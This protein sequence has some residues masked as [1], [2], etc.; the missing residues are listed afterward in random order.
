MCV[1]ASVWAW[2]SPRCSFL[3]VSCRSLKRGDFSSWLSRAIES[4]GLGTG[5]TSLGTC[6]LFKVPVHTLCGNGFCNI[7]NSFTVMKP[8]KIA[9]Q[10]RKDWIKIYEEI[11]GSKSF[12]LLHIPNKPLFVPLLPQLKFYWSEKVLLKTKIFLIFFLIA[13]FNF[14]FI[15]NRGKVGLRVFAGNILWVF[16]LWEKTGATFVYSMNFH[17]S[18]SASFLQC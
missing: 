10:C 18:H 4:R 15:F 17:F 14:C 5:V 16:S 1:Q 2:L 6:P 11:F 8:W 7:W 13:T 9:I 3:D 12:H